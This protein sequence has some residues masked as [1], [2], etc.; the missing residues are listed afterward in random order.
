GVPGQ[1]RI[2]SGRAHPGAA[3]AALARPVGGGVRCAVV[4][5][6]GAV[7]LAT[8]QTRALLLSLRLESTDLSGN[9]ALDSA[10]CDGDRRRGA[11]VLHPED[12]PRPCA[13]LP[14]SVEAA[15]VLRF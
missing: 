1:R 15:W 8:D 6:R 9:T 2:P 14:R 11:R 3:L 13:A 7:A 5:L 12:L 10:A 4:Q